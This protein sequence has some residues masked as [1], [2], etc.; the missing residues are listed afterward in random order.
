MK[1]IVFVRD[2]GE[3]FLEYR[4][5]VFGAEGNIRLRLRRARPFVYVPD[6]LGKAA[7]PT[8]S[9]SSLVRFPPRII[10]FWSSGIFA[11]KMLSTASGQARIGMSVP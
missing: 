5:R 8:Q 4:N 6:F 1:F 3:G 10:S 7:K 11:A 9:F 2:I